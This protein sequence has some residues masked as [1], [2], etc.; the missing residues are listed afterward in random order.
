MRRNAG[1]LLQAVSITIALLLCR[2]AAADGDLNVVVLKPITRIVSSGED[3][4]AACQVSGKYDACTRIIA[5]HLHG[6]CAAEGTEWRMQATATFRPWIVLQRPRSFAHEL[7]HVDDIRRAAERHVLGLE[8]RR[9]SS[10]EACRAGATEADAA[11]G[12]TLMQFAL[13]SNFARHPHLRFL[14]GK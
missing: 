13:D 14:A 2:R 12:A 5:F 10:E 6:T 4:R 9:F 11:F 1:L 3:L 7:Q 8:L